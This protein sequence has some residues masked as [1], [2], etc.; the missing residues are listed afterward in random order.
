M[1]WLDM[2]RGAKYT[3]RATR[4][5]ATAR[6][7]LTHGGVSCARMGVGAGGGGAA[8][9]AL[10]LDTLTGGGGHMTIPWRVTVMARM[11]S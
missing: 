9:S 2:L 5:A 10:A 8:F 4:A 7:G 6:A 1:K 11:T 3:R